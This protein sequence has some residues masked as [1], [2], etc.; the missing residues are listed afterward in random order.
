[1]KSSVIELTCY[2]GALKDGSKHLA[3]AASA[4]A[5]GNNSRARTEYEEAKNDFNRCSYNS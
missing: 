5:N 3:A 4:G 2:S 1:M